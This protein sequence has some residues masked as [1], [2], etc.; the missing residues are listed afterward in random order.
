MAKSRGEKGQAVH[1]LVIALSLQPVA[2]ENVMK[3][4]SIP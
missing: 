1:I 2:F 3:S 4:D